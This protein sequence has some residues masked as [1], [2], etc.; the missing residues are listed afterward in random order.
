ML[1]NA[2]GPF[3]AAARR[4]SCGE[5]ITRSGPTQ[6]YNL[7]PGEATACA[8]SSTSRTGWPW[9]CCATN[10]RSPGLA[11][12][13]M[14][15]GAPSRPSPGVNATA[16]SGPRDALNAST[17]ASTSSNFASPPAACIFSAHHCRR[18]SLCWSCSWNMRLASPIVE[19]RF[20]MEA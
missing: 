14:K 15:T 4:S 2:V 8:G 13:A 3:C 19:P 16:T 11:T 9:A 12:S 17:R 1:A 10:S 18:G 6:T 7:S 5:A 20:G